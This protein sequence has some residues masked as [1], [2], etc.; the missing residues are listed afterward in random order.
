MA[1]ITDLPNELLESIALKL[2]TQYYSDAIFGNVLADFSLVCRA[3]YRVAFRYIHDDLDLSSM[4]QKRCTSKKICDLLR[5]IQRNPERGYVVKT[6]SIGP[7]DP[8]ELSNKWSK[9]ESFMKSYSFLKRTI[10]NKAL[11]EQDMKGLED[12]PMSVLVAVLLYTL[13]KLVY[14]HLVL[15]SSKREGPLLTRWLLLAIDLAPLP[16]RETMRGMELEYIEL[17][18]TG[19]VPCRT[20]LGALLELPNLESVRFSCEDADDTL[21]VGSRPEDPELSILQG[22]KQLA[23]NEDPEA[24]AP[25]SSVF[26]EAYGRFQSFDPFCKKKLLAIRNTSSITEFS[27]Y[28]NPCSTL[29]IPDIIRVPKGLKDFDCFIGS[30]TRDSRENVQA[31]HQ[32]LLEHKDTLEYITMSY[33]KSFEN[34]HN[35]NFQLDFSA[36]GRLESLQVSIILLVDID[37]HEIGMGDILPVNLENLAVKIRYPSFGGVRSWDEAVVGVITRIARMKDEKLEKLKSV[38]V[39]VINHPARASNSLNLKEARRMMDERGI[40]F[41]ATTYDPNRGTI[42]L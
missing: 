22:M 26:L 17:D 35:P 3:F 30:R 13:P 29:P 40:Q 31:V 37:A 41:R 7:W 10:E 25:L 8:T 34:R 33:Y 15:R 38:D 4:E 23:S 1:I 5:Q 19:M 36:F 27:F 32:A 14:I 12:H 2:R 28:N 20:T 39:K 6:L 18:G 16:F 24:T 9:M 42:D 21:L 11:Q